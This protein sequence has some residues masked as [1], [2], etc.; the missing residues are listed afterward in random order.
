M[1]VQDIPALPINVIAPDALV[2]ALQ[3]TD[4]IPSNN[5]LPIT[6][7]TAE[8]EIAD[9]ALYVIDP[10]EVKTAE[11]AK[12][13]LTE[14]I[15]EATENIISNQ[16]L[17][18][19]SKDIELLKGSNQLDNA[20]KYLNDF[21]DVSDKIKTSLKSIGEITKTEISNEQIIGFINEQK[22]MTNEIKNNL[23]EIGKSQNSTIYEK[24]IHNLSKLFVLPTI[25][26]LQN[27][28][29][30]PNPEKFAKMVPPSF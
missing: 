24:I 25:N 13:I 5:L 15:Q 1:A 6:E 27:L 17:S 21:V 22:E 30:N 23:L 10:T 28:Y 9:D 3:N 7:S 29:K 11:V 2:V 19:T 4:A 26:E 20:K 8:Q 16:P 14:Q 18:I 12:E